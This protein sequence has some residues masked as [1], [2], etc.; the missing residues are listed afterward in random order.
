MNN[1]FLQKIIIMSTVILASLLFILIIS[2][3][4]LKKRKIPKKRFNI[5]TAAVVMSVLSLAL[6]I[7]AVFFQA[8][9]SFAEQKLAQQD[10]SEAKRIFSAISVY[11]DSKVKL[12]ECGYAEANALLEEDNIDG[13]RAVLKHLG[14]YKDSRDLLM[15]CDYEDA[16]ALLS[17]GELEDAKKKFLEI[18]D[19]SDSE[20]MVNEC[21]YQ[22]ALLHKNSGDLLTAYDEFSALYGYKDSAN[23]KNSLKSDIYYKGAEAYRFGNYSLAKSCFDVSD[24]V[25]R[26]SDYRT[27]ISAHEGYTSVYE[28]KGLIGFEDANTLLLSDKYIYSF[29]KGTWRTGSSNSYYYNRYSYYSSYRYVQYYDSASGTSCSY[30][31]PVTGGDYYKL[32]DGVHYTGSDSSGWH[33]EWKFEIINENKVR[34]YCYKDDSTYVLERE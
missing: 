23:I 27:L 9:Y 10:Y 4:I 3:L 16:A 11:R 5:K 18:I 26:E 22:L 14:D 33:K 6:C 34:V 19:Y 20:D 12:K 31:L 7:V 21:D 29:L 17:N 8:M 32:S 13:A 28:L 1:A 25:G 30:N 24:N 2:L 15:Q